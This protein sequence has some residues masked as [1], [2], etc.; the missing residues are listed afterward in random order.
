MP[1]L[2]QTLYSTAHY[3]VSQIPDLE[4]YIQNRIRL[5][6]Y[7]RDGLTIHLAELADVQRLTATLD[8]F[9][10]GIRITERTRRGDVCVV[11]YKHGVLAHVR[12]AALHPLSLSTLGGHTMQIQPNEA[13][14]YD[15]YTMPAFRQQG[16]ASE[17]RIVLM[18]YL[19]QQGVHAAYTDA[20]LDNVHNQ[21][22]WRKRVREGRQRIIGVITVTKRLG[23]M[24][25]TF[26]AETEDTRPLIARLY[27][28][29]PHHVQIRSIY[30][31]LGEPQP[32]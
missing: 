11:A 23:Q 16:I 4:T 21:N 12:W 8:K 27:G 18:Q 6:N 32:A 2:L 17:A 31:F 28:V 19:T 24:R 1:Q 7:D 29:P 3:R 9:R 22:T 5:A 20:R 30:Q 15:S 26:F 14:T 25:C 13:Y 10:D